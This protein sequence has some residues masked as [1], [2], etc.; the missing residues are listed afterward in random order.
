MSIPFKYAIENLR[1][2]RATAGATIAGISLVVFVFAAV[3][4][5]AHGVDKTLAQTGAKDNVV[6]TRKGSNGEISSIVLGETI[7]IIKSLPHI[8]Q[9]TDGTQLVTTEPVV[10]INLHKPDGGMS[11]VTVRG[12]SPTAFELRPKHK[13]VAGRMFDPSLRELIVGKPLTTKFT[14]AGIG[15]K[16]KFAG[17]E[18]EVVGAFECGGGGFESEI[19]GNSVQLQGAFNRGSSCSSVTL[20]LTSAGDFDAF[21]SMFESDTRLKEFEVDTEQGYFAKQSEDLAG[22]IKILGIFITVIFSI[23][24][25]VGAMITMYGAVANRTVEI[26]TMRSLGFSRRSVL[27]V[28][29]AEAIMISFIGSIIGILLASVL[30]FYQVSTLN[31]TS[32]AEIA[33]SFALS[34]TIIVSSILFGVGMGFLGGFLPA[35]RAA[36]MN[37]VNALRAS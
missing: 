6:I 17:D 18:W 10:V 33:F 5:M 34:P 36:R 23:G 35:V 4:M 14:D 1:I 15:N 27:A 7:G 37:I 2:R 32:F 11:N 26:G 22:F 24:A 12:V 8:K 31:F 28:F 19:W 25:T 20:K 9:S 13:I 16:V 21:K 29:L 30:Q 3:L